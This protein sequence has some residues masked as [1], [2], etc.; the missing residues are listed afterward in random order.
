MSFNFQYIILPFALV[1]ITSCAYFL[2]FKSPK[3]ENFRIY[4]EKEV[5]IQGN[6]DIKTSGFY[7]F[8]YIDKEINYG[9]QYTGYY[10]FK[11]NGE[12]HI[13]ENVPKGTPDSTYIFMQRIIELDLDKAI[14]GYYSASGSNVKMEYVEE[15]GEKLKCVFYESEGTLSK[16]GDTLYIKEYR[17]LKDGKPIVLQRK[18][19]Y[20]PFK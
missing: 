8:S 17:K 13:E 6:S 14:Y 19:I 11:P 9:R 15:I 2:P 16:N 12:L 20:Y 3:P 18:C 4:L 10:R 1:I 5:G 7:Y